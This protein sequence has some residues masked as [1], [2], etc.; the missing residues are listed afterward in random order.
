MK[1][2]LNETAVARTGA[3]TE[4]T[5]AVFSGP[6]L[7]N[8]K[9]SAANSDDKARDG[10]NE[11]RCS[12]SP[13]RADLAAR[14]V[15]ESGAHRNSY[16]KNREHPVAVPLGIKVGDHSR[17]ENAERSLTDSDDGVANIERPVAVN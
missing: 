11:E 9:N 7:R 3:E 14:D 13:H 16:V 17:C 5:I 8:K 4:F 6:V 2:R 15:T 12:P 10:T 1:K